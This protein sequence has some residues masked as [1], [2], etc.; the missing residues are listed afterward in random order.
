[1]PSFGGGAGAPFVPVP[2][3]PYDYMP[4]WCTG[5]L[6]LTKYAQQYIG[7]ECGF[8]GVSRD[9]EASSVIWTLFQRQ[10]LARALC[11]A[12]EEIEQVAGFFLE[13]KWVENEVHPC[14]P[15]GNYVL[16]WNHVIEGGVPVVDAID[17][18]AVVNHAADPAVIGPLATTATDTAEIKVYYPN[19]KQEIIPSNI[20]IAGGFVTIYIPRCR[21]VDM[22]TVDNPEE[23]LDYNTPANFQTTVD[24]YHVYTDTTD[25]GEF[26]QRTIGTCPPDT[27][28]LCMDIKDAE[29]SHV[30]A[31]QTGTVS[32]ACRVSKVDQARVNYVS[33]LSY[34]DRIADLAV[35]RLAHSKMPGEPCGYDRIKA[36]WRSDNTIPIV[37]SVERL[38]C[39]F[40]VSNGA[41]MA[42]KFAGSISEDRMSVF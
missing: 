15:T 10:E 31:Y 6:S 17:A 33:G 19:T 21:L 20:V 35:V 29:I 38:E 8:W 23:G 41:W 27:L 12:Q 7:Y 1:M 39:P 3:P 4:E 25:A 16:T 24:V 34:L 22:N 11:E 2:D 40:G 26:L 30:L 9:T 42:W 13:P 28:A 18:G 36:M 14:S 37:L 5:A 32:A